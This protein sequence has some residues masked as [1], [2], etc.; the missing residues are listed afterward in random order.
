[1]ST[2]SAQATLSQVTPQTI[3]AAITVIVVLPVMLFY[4]FMQ[5]HFTKGLILG[6]V[7]G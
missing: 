5:R 1:M 6:A 4:P 7:K 2:S 3:R